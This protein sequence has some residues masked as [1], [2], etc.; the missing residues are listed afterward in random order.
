MGAEETKGDGP[1]RRTDRHNQRHR[2]VKGELPD[3]RPISGVVWLGER[4]VWKGKM[5]QSLPSL[6][7]IPVWLPQHH[8]V[9]PVLHGTV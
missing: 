6:C 2:G 4:R 9:G 1:S 8:L 7:G 3:R 5:G